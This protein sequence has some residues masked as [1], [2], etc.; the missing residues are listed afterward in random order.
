MKIEVLKISKR[1]RNYQVLKELSLEVKEGENMVIIG[2]SGCGKTVLLKHIIGLLKPDSGKILIDGEEAADRDALGLKPL[3]KKFGIVFQ[4][5]AL[6]NS[7]TVAENIGIGLKEARTYK[8]EEIREIVEEKLKLVGLEDIGNRMPDE[9]S[10]GMKKRVAL[11]R[12]LAMNPEI[13]L[14]DEP[15]SELDP[16]M[17]NTINQLI[18]DLKERLRVT[19]VTVTHDINHAYLIGDRIAVLH[20]GRIMKIATPEEIRTSPDPIIGQFITRNEWSKGKILT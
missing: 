11:A 15:T 2:G 14:Y 10:G 6:F 7:L 5:S 12:A 9:L 8:E 17:A 19:S 13:M 3:R 1:F 16:F 20:E 4:S 18:L